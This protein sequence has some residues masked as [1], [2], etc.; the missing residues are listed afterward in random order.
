MF[1]TV[2]QN[3]TIYQC[4]CQLPRPTKRM[5]W[6]KKTSIEVKDKRMSKKAK[7]QDHV[8]VISRSLG[9]SH[10]GTSTLLCHPSFLWVLGHSVLSPS[11]SD[12][13]SYWEA[14]RGPPQDSRVIKC[15]GFIGRCLEFRPLFYY[16]LL[17]ART[18]LNPWCPSFLISK[19]GESNENIIS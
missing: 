17:V 16:L 11:T 14:G 15:A 9:I 5:Q 18:L 3:M 12:H 4:L 10:V 7:S 6:S 2:S 1:D 8:S 13:V 19:N